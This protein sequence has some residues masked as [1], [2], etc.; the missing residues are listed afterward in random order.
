MVL[1][2]QGYI[3][4]ST[5]LRCGNLALKFFLITSKICFIIIVEALSD[6]IRVSFNL[7]KTVFIIKLMLIKH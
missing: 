7:I 5:C 2:L 1:V 3:I 4:K 6:L